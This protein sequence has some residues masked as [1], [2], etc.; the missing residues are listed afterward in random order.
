[1]LYSTCRLPH[2]TSLKTVGTNRF[3]LKLEIDVP[4]DTIARIAETL[5]QTAGPPSSPF[6]ITSLLLAVNVSS[7]IVIEQRN[8]TN[9]C[10]T[11]LSEFEV[12]VNPT[13][14]HAIRRLDLS[15]DQLSSMRKVYREYFAQ[16]LK[17]VAAAFPKLEDF[18]FDVCGTLPY[19]SILYALSTQNY[20]IASRI[21]DLYDKS[22]ALARISVQTGHNLDVWR[23]TT[24]GSGDH[25][26]VVWDLETSF[27]AAHL[28]GEPYD[29]WKLRDDL[30]GNS[31]LVAIRSDGK[32]LYND[33][34]KEEATQET[35]HKAVNEDERKDCHAASSRPDAELRDE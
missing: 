35:A 7:L 1:M 18:N 22:D 33:L 30:R 23:K 16:V 21:Q 9:I 10:I 17:V 19:Y 4:F 8:S 25:A 27:A 5:E 28:A 26:K 20:P 6:I 13:A 34:P 32:S 14:P 11:P 12:P 29:L 31:R 15:S 2:G 24:K 3:R